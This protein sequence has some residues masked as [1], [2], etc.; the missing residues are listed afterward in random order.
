VI[1]ELGEEV[2]V[3]Q[4]TVDLHHT[5]IKDHFRDHQCN[6]EPAISVVADQLEVV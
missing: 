6:L 2:R 4:P 5:I 1:I 3:V